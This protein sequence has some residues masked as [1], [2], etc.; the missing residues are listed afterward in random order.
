[1]AVIRVVRKTDGKTIHAYAADAPV[2]F[3]AYPFADFHHL[4]EVNVNPD[5]S[6]NAND[7]ARRVTKLE[8]VG[9]LG[10]AAY[11]AILG[12]AKQSVD[13]EA[14]VMMLSLATPDAD[15][16]SIDLDDQRTSAGL[17][18]LEPALV[19]LGVAQEGWAAGVLA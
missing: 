8:F 3:D 2:E 6:I 10:D 11:K 12:L 15:G 4:V 13:V 16:T 7:N 1:M 9:R 5:G 18:A 19:A 17:A 14:F